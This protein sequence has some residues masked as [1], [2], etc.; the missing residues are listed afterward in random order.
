MGDRG[1]FLLILILLFVRAS[2][3]QSIS[4][5]APERSPFDLRITAEIRG[6][7]P[8]AIRIQDSD[9]TSAAF[10]SAKPAT[11]FN[12]S[13]DEARRVGS[14]I[15]TDL[16]ILIRSGTQRRAALGRAD[17][18]EAFAALYF[19]S[20]RTGRLVLWQILS[21]D[22]ATESAAQD[23][24]LRT[25]PPL[26]LDLVRTARSLVGKEASD[27]V[28]SAPDEVPAEGSPAAKGF[29]SPVPY[30]RLKPEYTRIAYL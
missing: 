3:G 11:P 4:I 6:D 13:T 14:I 20:S 28:P 26:I 9:M 2:F 25:M 29:R 5:V 7:L 17:Y 27:P 19:I 12:M 22:G 16:F 21:K 30:R 8:E 24:L 23:D 1:L 15:G 18:H 10:D